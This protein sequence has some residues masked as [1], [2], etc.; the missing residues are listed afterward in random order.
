MK[1]TKRYVNVKT[2]RSSQGACLVNGCRTPGTV[3]ATRIRRGLRL[4]VR[5][6]TD[7]ATL[8]GVIE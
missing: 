2:Y 8:G 1:V 6:C 7:H 3:Q 5:Y 4:D